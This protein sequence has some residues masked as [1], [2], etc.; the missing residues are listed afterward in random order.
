M[1]LLIGKIVHVIGNVLWLGGG[2][3]AAFAFAQLGSEAPA[4][5]AAA[6]RGLRV[7]VLAI[8]TPGMLLSLGAGLV[9]LLSYWGELYARAPWMHT[10][11]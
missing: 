9:M 6:A 5:R 7:A 2:A 11:L 10:K 4:T 1:L 8:V 3:V